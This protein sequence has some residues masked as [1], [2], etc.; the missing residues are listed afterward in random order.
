LVGVCTLLLGSCSFGGPSRPSPLPAAQQKAHIGLVIFDHDLHTLDPVGANNY[1][2]DGSGFISSLIFPPLLT[3]DDHLSPEPWAAAGMP[4]FNAAS[5]IYTFTIRPGLKWSDGNP[6]DANTYAYSLNRDLS[7]CSG[8]PN[9]Y[10]LFAI[11]DAEAFSTETCNPVGQ[12]VQGKIQTLIGD[13]LL[14]PDTQTLIIKLTAPA[15]YLLAALTTPL[16]LAQPEQLI[17]Q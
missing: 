6:I 16:G 17:T 5:N 11:K 2:G 13:S 14:V 8:S 1:N 10:Y 15:P 4:T 7:P 9:I 3:V 12:R